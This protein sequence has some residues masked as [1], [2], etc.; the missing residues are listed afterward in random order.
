[1]LLYAKTDE[2]ETPYGNSIISGNAINVRTLDLN[3]GFEE[4]SKQLDAIVSEAFGVDK[5][6]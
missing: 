3:C 4:I 5:K 1:M 6:R 2:D